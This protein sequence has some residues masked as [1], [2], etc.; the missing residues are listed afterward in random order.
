M[1]GQVECIA[2]LLVF[3]LVCLAIGLAFVPAVGPFLAVAFGIVAVVAILWMF[4][5]FASGRTPAGVARQSGRH[6]E[7]PDLLGPGG[8]DDPD[9]NL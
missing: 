1:L 2:A 8:S 4:G 7:M 3:L 9:R 6:K 5:V